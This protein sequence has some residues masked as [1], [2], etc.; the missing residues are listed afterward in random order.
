LFLSFTGWGV[1][2]SPCP[3]TLI[4]PF[5]KKRKKGHMNKM[6]RIGSFI[7]NVKGKFYSLSLL[8]TLLLGMVAAIV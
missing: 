3:I 6:V 2:F 7:Q 5:K 8:F 1:L 4:S